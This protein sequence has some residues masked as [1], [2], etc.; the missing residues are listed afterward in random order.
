MRHLAG[1]LCLFLLLL[2]VAH[3]PSPAQAQSIGPTTTASV[4]QAVLQ[5]RDTLFDGVARGLNKCSVDGSVFLLNSAIAALQSGDRT[6]ARI[7]L[8]AA[9]V[10]SC[11]LSREL[12]PNTRQAY[13]TIGN[14]IDLADWL[15]T[16]DA[17]FAGESICA[18]IDAA[19]RNL[20]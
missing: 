5:T 13:R 20:S 9:L 16:P 17:Q 4:L 18:E 14:L 2:A 10:C 3:W 1:R 12:N 15:H 11:R 7:R 19:I 8:G 6:A